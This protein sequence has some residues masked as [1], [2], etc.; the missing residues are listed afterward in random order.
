M[1]VREDYDS[2]YNTDSQSD[3]DDKVQTKKQKLTHCNADSQSDEEEIKQKL[4]ASDEE[5]IIIA[6]ALSTA[7][8]FKARVNEETRKLT[9]EMPIEIID[10][11]IDE[12]ADS[13]VCSI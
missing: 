2:Q 7:S 13:D 11:E 3:E 10:S 4:D 5:D 8:Q 9:R 12:L 1:Q 6:K